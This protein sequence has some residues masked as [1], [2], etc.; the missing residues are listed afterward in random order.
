MVLASSQLLWSVGCSYYS[1]A[2]LLPGET[3]GGSS[4]GVGGSGGKVGTSPPGGAAGSSGASHSGGAGASSTSAGKGGD[5]ATGGTGTAGSV[6]DSGEGG[7]GGEAPS[8]DCPEDLDKTQPGECGCGIA[9]I[10]AP[11][12]AALVHRYS[13]EVSGTLATD[14]IGSADA[15]I[16]GTTAADGKVSLT[17]GS[18]AAYVDLPNGMI[19]ALGDASFEVWLQWT[20]GGSWQRI[21]DFGSNDVGEGSQGTG[22]TYLYLTPRDGDASSGN[23]LRASFSLS[24]IGGETTIRTSAPLPTTSAQHV[25][26]VVDDTNNQLRLYLNGALSSMTA[27]NGS[28]SSLDD[29]NNWLG[30]SNYKDAHLA[31][32]IEEFRVY[33]AALSDALVQASSGFGPSPAFL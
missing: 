3:A 8:D 32:S 19:S 15:D 22:Q 33:G 5:E 23:P 31:G 29:V 30:R 27:F 9:E 24:G 14:S 16:I 6:S 26:L 4:S 10:C 18:T 7:S 1:E 20:G 12:K 17:G 11:L 28:L 13:F 21:F 2:L 25:V